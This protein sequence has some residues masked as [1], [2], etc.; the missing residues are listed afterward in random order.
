MPLQLRRGTE[1]ERQALTAPLSNGEPLWIPVT[2]QLYIGD[3]IT[4]TNL[5]DSV[6]SHSG[7]S[8]SVS[9]T[10][11]DNPVNGNLWYDTVSGSLYIYLLNAWVEASPS[12]NISSGDFYGSIFT[13]DGATQ[14]IDGESG[15]ITSDTIS[16]VHNFSSA[17]Q[18]GTT[19]TNG[20]GVI[21]NNAGPFVSMYTT[22]TNP[23][24]KISF[25]TSTGTITNPGPVTTNS[26]LGS[27][28]FTGLVTS[29][30]YDSAVTIDA[31]ADAVI[32]NNKVPGRFVVT[33]RSA[34]GVNT[35]TLTF[36]SS[37]NLSVPT[38]TGSLIGNADTA[39]IAKGINVYADAA[40]R[41]ASI[42]PGERTIGMLAMLQDDGTGNSATSQYTAAGWVTINGIY[43]MKLVQVKS[44]LIMALP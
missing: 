27:I 40:D 9:D 26:K 42:S 34:N 33:T 41:D 19:T 16:S 43:L 14:I 13:L 22:T 31:F 23:N 29:A 25:N 18:L 12:P 6:S 32:T 21:Y 11:P 3:G 4:P 7:G 30:N 38:V 44:Y 36:D 15:Y 37:G 17:L 5:L 2:G 39:T 20:A 35:N 10:A 1:A 8:T 28:S 24:P